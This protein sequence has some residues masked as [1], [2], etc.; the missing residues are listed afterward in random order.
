MNPRNNPSYYTRL[1]S[2]EYKEL[3]AVRL[4]NWIR[5]KD[6]ERG[7]EMRTKLIKDQTYHLELLEY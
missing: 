4:Q 3:C 5:R 7:I 1:C 2:P 6:L